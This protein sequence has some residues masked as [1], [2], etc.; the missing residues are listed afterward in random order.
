MPDIGSRM[1]IWAMRGCI[2]G[3]MAVGA[4][5]AT[6]NW[7]RGMYDSFIRTLLIVDKTCRYL[8]YVQ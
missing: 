3:F 7:M 8:Y 5:G 4:L 2:D 1:S 6:T